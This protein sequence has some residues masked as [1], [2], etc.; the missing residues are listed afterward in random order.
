M[1]K[2][3]VA[4]ILLGVV[5]DTWD[6]EGHITARSSTDNISEAGFIEAAEGFKGDYIQ[7]PPVYSAKKISGKPAYYYAR[8]KGVDADKIILKKNT[9]KIYDISTEFF[10]AGKAVLKIKCSSGTYVRSVV[11]EIGQRLGCGAILTGLQRTAIGSFSSENSMSL[12]ELER[13]SLAGQTVIEDLQKNYKGIISA[14]NI[15]Y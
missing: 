9:V 1:D 7:Q 11:H 2:T 15:L 14:E 8:N 3:Y 4:Q 12:E 6:S 5:T 13:I 10:Y